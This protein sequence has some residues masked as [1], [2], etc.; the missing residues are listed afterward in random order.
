MF[1]TE[2]NNEQTYC[3]STEIYEH[4]YEQSSIFPIQFLL[5][6]KTTQ[7][8]KIHLT[9]HISQLSVTELPN[10]KN[11]IESLT[12]IQITDK[13]DRRIKN[14]CMLKLMPGP[15]LHQSLAVSSVNTCEHIPRAKIRLDE[16]KECISTFTM[17]FPI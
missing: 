15:E 1:K 3:T 5:S 14:E 9:I 10:R 4:K 7:F 8:H 12:R 11:V 13:G 16:H 2:D 17:Y 6:I